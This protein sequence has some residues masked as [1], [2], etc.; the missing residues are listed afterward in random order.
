M[1]D[2]SNRHRWEPVG[3]LGPYPVEVCHHC[4]SVAVLDA[5]GHPPAYETV[6]ALLR[7]S[8]SRR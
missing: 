8:W 1:R 7:R 5:T 2:V 6:I 3:V 4:E